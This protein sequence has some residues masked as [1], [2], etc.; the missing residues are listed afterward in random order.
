MYM[1][2]YEDKAYG[3]KEIDVKNRQVI[4]IGIGI[5]A[6]AIMLSIGIHIA[7]KI[8]INNFFTAEWGAGDALNYVASILSAA[9]TIILGYIAYKQ[10]DRLQNLEN[11][12]YIANYSSM[13]LMNE[14]CIKWDVAVPVNWQIHSEQIVVDDDLEETSSYVGYKFTFNVASIGNHTPALVHIQECTIF[15]SD[16]NGKATKGHLFGKNYSDAYSRVAIHK[17]GKIKFEMT[18]VIN[19]NRKL[20][21]EEAIKQNSYSVLVEVVFNIITDKN[22]ITRCKCRAKCYRDNSVSQI[23]WKDKESMVFFYGH[24]IANADQIKVAGEK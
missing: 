5:S 2:S 18:Y 20:D 12:N 11:N 15:C 17:E 8:H 6:I 4:S 13:I 24:S 16:D 19:A 3:R 22:V 14:I 21:F 1:Y 7:F 23:V 9:G 10:N